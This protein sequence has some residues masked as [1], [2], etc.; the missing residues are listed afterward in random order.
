MIES[1]LPV[2]DKLSLNMVK[3]FLGVPENYF[4]MIRWGV[5]CVVI[6][7]MED[8]LYI[9][10]ESNHKEREDFLFEIKAVYVWSRMLKILADSGGDI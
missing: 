10:K 6:D 2:G 5:Y 9:L 3:E 4:Q 1:K 7:F 8:R